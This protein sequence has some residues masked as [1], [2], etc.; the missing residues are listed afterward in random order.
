MPFKSRKQQGFM[1][2]THPKKPGAA[3]LV[4]T[5]PPKPDMSAYKPASP[6]ATGPSLS[7]YLDKKK[8]KF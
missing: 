1:F 2:A 6:V 8:V 5:A 7:D 4:N 3:P